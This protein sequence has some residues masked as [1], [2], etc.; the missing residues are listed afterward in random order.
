MLW[1]IVTTKWIRN[2]KLQS[3]MKELKTAKIKKV[4]IIFVSENLK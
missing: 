4:L 1:V 2:M 3:V